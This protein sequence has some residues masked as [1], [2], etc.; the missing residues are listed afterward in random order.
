MCV[1]RFIAL[2]V[3]ID[4]VSE[5]S[6]LAQLVR[7]RARVAIAKVKEFQNSF[8]TYRYLWSGDRVEFMRQ[9]LLYGHA[10]SPEEAELY[11][12]YELAKN[13]PKLQNFKEQVRLHIP[14]MK[15]ISSPHYF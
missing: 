9:F 12:E 10:L 11:A 4:Q 14:T 7:H 3:D 13:P 5:L 6:E 1:V 2:Q 8:S 15:N